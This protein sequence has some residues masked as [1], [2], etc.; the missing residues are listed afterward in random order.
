MDLVLECSGAWY[1]DYIL[2]AILLFSQFLWN[3]HWVYPM[4]SLGR[5]PMG[6]GEGRGREGKGAE[7]S[8]R[9]GRRWDGNGT[10]S[11]N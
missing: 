11:Y 3:S 8:G 5:N 1:V 9:E 2:T 4:V 10:R 6:W 7:G